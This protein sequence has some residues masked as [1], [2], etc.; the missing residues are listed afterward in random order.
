MDVV[1]DKDGAFKLLYV[2]IPVVKNCAF[3]QPLKSGFKDFFTHHYILI[4]SLSF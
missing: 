2:R 3:H 1:R 4:S